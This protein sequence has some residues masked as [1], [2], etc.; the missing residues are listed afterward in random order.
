[1]IEFKT[2][3]D[4]NGKKALVTH[5]TI[6]MPALEDKAFADFILGKVKDESDV[7]PDMRLGILSAIMLTQ[8]FHLTQLSTKGMLYLFDRA[9]TVSMS[10]PQPLKIALIDAFADVLELHLHKVPTVIHAVQLKFRPSIME[11]Q[12]ALYFDK[13]YLVVHFDVTRPYMVT[14]VNL[15]HDVFQERPNDST[16]RRALDFYQRISVMLFLSDVAMDRAQI[17]LNQVPDVAV[18]DFYPV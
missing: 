2:P 9:G 14:V 10:A 13:E 6:P 3:V 16:A 1:M 11:L 18:T 8:P 7:H 17:L 4:F 15:I 12:M 5:K